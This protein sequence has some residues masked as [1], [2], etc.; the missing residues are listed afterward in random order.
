M[1]VVRARTSEARSAVAARRT[2]ASPLADGKQTV[3]P[4]SERLCWRACKPHRALPT[5][6]VVSTSGLRSTFVAMPA[7]L[8]LING[9]RIDVTQDAESAALQLWDSSTGFWTFT[10]VGKRETPVHVSAAA[11]LWI[12]ERPEHSSATFT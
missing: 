10:R 3:R 2:E 1:C 12:E 4:V 11:V 9:E 8:H 7:R 5:L 6:G